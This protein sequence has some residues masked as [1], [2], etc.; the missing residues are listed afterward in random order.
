M[1]VK[2]LR[3]F[4]AAVVLVM[5]IANILFIAENWNTENIE[6]TAKRWKFEKEVNSKKLVNGAIVSSSVEAAREDEALLTADGMDIQVRSSKEKASV[7]VDGKVV[8]EIDKQQ[9]RGIIAF[10]LNQRTGALMAVRAF[11]TYASKDEGQE[12]VKFIET[13]QEG[14][15][16]CLAI[17]DEG[18]N[19]L[20]SDARSYI[21]KLGSGYVNI[22]GWRD[23][24][25]F[26]FQRNSSQK[27]VFAEIHQISPDSDSW[28]KNVLIRT[29]LRREMGVSSECGWHDNDSN[30]RRRELCQKFEGY[31]RVCHCEDSESIDFNPPALEDGSR[32]NLPVLVMASNR[33]QYLFRMLKSLRGVRGLNPAMVTVYIDGFFDEPAL[34]ARMF[35]LKV[36]QHEGV[37][38]G[39][40]RIC[41]HYKKSITTSFDQF[42]DAN[43]VV[44]I[45][46][47]LDVSVDILTYF[48]Q[49]LPVLENDESVY[50]IS[51]WNDQGYD[52]TVNDPSMTYR[53]ET[54]PGLGW[55]LSRK[56][57]KGELEP[58]WP[59]PD[60][61][62]DWDM[63]MR[64]PE[65]RKGRECIIPDISR[66]YHFGATG[67]NVHPAM[68]EAYFKKHALNTVSNVK[69]NPDIMYKDNYEQ[70]INRLIS[71]AELLDHLRT[72]CTNSK[73]FVPDTRNK[74]YLFYIRMDHAEDYTT[75]INVARCFKIWDLDARGFHKSLWRMWIKGNH[76]MY[77]GC[78]ASPYCNHRPTNIEPIYM[79]NTETRPS[80]ENFFAK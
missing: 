49:L 35:G 47:D 70:E 33:P 6:R 26:I 53:I 14:R 45:E 63:W 62:W 44:I 21:E 18:T 22:I 71:Q 32:I 52:Y 16:V 31:G 78:P 12:I 4:L 51:A 59:A 10:V 23:M 54:M 11:D 79:P 28:A 24:W 46:E 55:V 56:L 64:M 29:S 40:S 72:P 2:A 76:V 13:L 20:E 50:C 17:K 36:D 39:N 66:T 19:N 42:P 43:S 1:A 9:M 7:V 41:Q 69:I 61:F 38:R 34:V 5:S 74:I 8:S 27:R 57:F 3:I 75:W 60:D 77:V 73:D 25:A 67:L 58:K 30:L 37:S 48:N 68:N 65:Q 80:D 15:I